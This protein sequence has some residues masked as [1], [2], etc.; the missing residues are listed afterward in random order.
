LLSAAVIV[1]LVM[2]DAT[3]LV[4]SNAR[5]LGAPILS[6]GGVPDAAQRQQLIDGDLAAV[7]FT[8]VGNQ[9]VNACD[10]LE[11]C[12]KVMDTICVALSTTAVRVSLDDPKNCAG[13]CKDKTFKALVRCN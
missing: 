4:V 6:T 5:K 1:P 12:G 7:R 10:N 13:H 8:S 9:F 3:I 11:S 2:A